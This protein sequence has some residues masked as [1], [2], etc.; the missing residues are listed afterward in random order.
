MSTTARSAPTSTRTRPSPAP[1][2]AAKPSA[3]RAPDPWLDPTRT[4]PAAGT[5]ASGPAPA[6]PPVK[7]ESHLDK[8]TRRQHEITALLGRLDGESDADYR[9]R[10]MPMITTGLAIPRAHADE[11]RKEAQTAANVTPEQSQRL[12]HAFDKVY[13]SLL[14]YTNKAIGAGQLSPY[15]TDVASMMQYAGGLGAVLEDSSAQIGQILSADQMKALSDNGF[16]WSEYLSVSA[17]WEKLNAPPP[18]PH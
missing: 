2:V 15:T 12:D 11:M 4:Q 16:D 8:R 13:D 5:R 3:A 9:A 18:P 7:E 1:V 17:P 10:V 14:D 6:L